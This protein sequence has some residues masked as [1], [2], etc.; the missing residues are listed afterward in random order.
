MDFRCQWPPGAAGCSWSIG[1]HH[2]QAR[3]Q[4]T[5]VT[6]VLVC[7]WAASAPGTYPARILVSSFEKMFRHNFD[8]QTGLRS[9]VLEKHYIPILYFA[10]IPPLCL[11]TLRISRVSPWATVQPWAGVSGVWSTACDCYRES[12]REECQTFQTSTPSGPSAQESGLN[13]L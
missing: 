6:T 2:R 8:T 13:H 7:T 9:S 12:A 1:W 11:L 4:R 3:E 10:C 5:G